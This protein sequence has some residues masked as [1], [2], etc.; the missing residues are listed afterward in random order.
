LT[1]NYIIILYVALSIST[2]QE[3]LPTAAILYFTVEDNLHSGAPSGVQ[4]FTGDEGIL[5]TWDSSMDEDF[6]YHR[7]YRY[8]TDSGDPAIQFTTVD[9]FYVDDAA[10]GNYEYWITA[11]DLNGNESDPSG[12]TTEEI[13]TFGDHFTTA[14]DSS[15]KIS[16]IA[17]AKVDSLLELRGLVVTDCTSD[18]CA[19][20]IGADLGV[21]YVIAGSVI[22]MEDSTYTITAKML[23]VDAYMEKIEESIIYSGTLQGLNGQAEILAWK[24]LNLEEELVLRMKA[25][26]LF[27]IKGLPTWM[28]N[29]NPYWCG[30][31][32]VAVGGG[33]A[34]MI[35][36]SDGGSDGTSPL[37]EPPN[38]PSAP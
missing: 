5:L 28:I 27:G 36:G 18:S 16:V 11:V 4:A 15:G 24:L 8:D 19:I 32:L 30:L 20:S 3:A 23:T 35:G 31:G 2:A 9:T 10:E 1:K 37:G 29:L 38:F 14:L 26:G 33:V 22:K 17:Q 13:K 21:S 34:I 12:P 25:G 6:G 7:I